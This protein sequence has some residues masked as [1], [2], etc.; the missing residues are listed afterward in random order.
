MANVSDGER[1]P[2]DLANEVLC[3]LVC[4]G[5][6]SDEMNLRTIAAFGQREPDWSQIVRAAVYNRVA[7]LAYLNLRESELG[8]AMPRQA[9]RT[10]EV[11]YYQSLAGAT[12]VRGNLAGL[13]HRFRQETIPA[14][15]LRGLLL[16]EQVYGDPALRPFSDTDLLVHKR[17]VPR[18]KRL[19]LDLGYR[20]QPH[21]IDAC[22]FEKHHLH[23]V[24]AGPATVEL[25]WALDH[26]YTPFAIDC[27][28][29]FAT[30]SPGELAGV[31]ALL[32]SAE[33][34]LL[35]LCVHLLKH[36]YYARYL[37]S[38]QD[39]LRQVLADGFLVLYADVDAVVRR[40][41]ET[42]DWRVIVDR[43]RRWQ[44]EPAVGVALGLV[45]RW[46][47]TPVPDWVLDRLPPVMAGSLESCLAAKLFQSDG[48]GGVVRLGEMRP[49][50]LFRPARL[51]GLLNYVAPSPAYIAWRYGTTGPVR[52]PL[53]YM[54]HA[55]TA[56]AEICENTFDY[57]L[58]CRI[59]RRR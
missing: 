13:L 41:A 11:A 38:A 16:G 23:L 40:N 35:T 25:H 4:V 36:C 12:A 34:L 52:L 44:I 59:R 27:A 20:I 58:Y 28:E 45:T 54:C 48:Q 2:P 1:V 14:L 47:R 5:T 56:A 26:K 17:D 22:Y 33:S 42:L 9:L 6:R 55:V 57:L 53:G 18:A 8:H 30:T 24:F 51:F 19:L 31:P 37:S 15:V 50:A 7:P 43:A 21:D 32:L 49:D 39:C 10:L 3:L 29:V 46:F